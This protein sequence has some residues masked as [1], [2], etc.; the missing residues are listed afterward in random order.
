HGGS[1]D[2]LLGSVR[3]TGGSAGVGGRDR[4]RAVAGSL[5]QCLT[6]LNSG[7]TWVPPGCCSGVRSLDS[8]A[9]TPADRQAVCNC[10]KSAASSVPASSLGKAAGIPGKCGVNIPYKISPSIDCSQ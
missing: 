9:T 3:D 5:A 6:Y 4:V 2:R 10:L 1:E 7:A 8:M